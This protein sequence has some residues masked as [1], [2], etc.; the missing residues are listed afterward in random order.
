MNKKQRKQ[1]SSF[2]E[3][4]QDTH[5]DQSVMS[6]EES[7]SVPPVMLL[8]YYL[9][10]KLSAWR[11]NRPTPKEVLSF[12]SLLG[13]WFSGLLEMLEVEVEGEHFNIFLHRASLAPKERELLQ[14]ILEYPQSTAKQ[15]RERLV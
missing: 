7:E 6:G 1:E 9:E 10:E 5:H 4:I 8:R 3:A 15:V 13:Q 12:L 2:E 14:L 11:E